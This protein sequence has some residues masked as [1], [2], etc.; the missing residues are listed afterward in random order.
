[1][2]VGYVLQDTLKPSP[3]E[4]QVMKKA[5]AIS[6][7]ITTLFYMSCGVF[8]Y[9]AFGNQAPGNLLTG[10]GFNGPFWLVDYANFC[11][12]VHLVGAYQVIKT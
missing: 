10:F 3:P 8:G 2:V 5:S 11:V 6:V 7:S 12:I 9:L 4:N 1:M